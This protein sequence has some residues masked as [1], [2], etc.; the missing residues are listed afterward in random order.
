MGNEV[1]RLQG[2]PY[3]QL[4]AAKMLQ[5]EYGQ[6]VGGILQKH[7]RWTKRPQERPQVRQKWAW[8]A[9]TPQE[10][11]Q[12]AVEPQETWAVAQPS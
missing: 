6:G 3:G 8:V 11:P 4:R 5:Q 7:L 9:V 10:K 1:R 12:A 2:Q